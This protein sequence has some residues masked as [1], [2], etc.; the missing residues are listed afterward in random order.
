V[1]QH[2][3]VMT[4]GMQTPSAGHI[5]DGNPAVHQVRRSFVMATVDVVS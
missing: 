2:N 5:R 4:G 1:P 3:Q